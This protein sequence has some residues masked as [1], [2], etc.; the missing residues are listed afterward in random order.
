MD[1]STRM[2]RLRALPSI[3]ELLARPSVSSLLASHSRTLGVTA[4]RE[5]VAGLRARILKGED[6]QIEAKA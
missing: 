2:E 3:D 4:V 6:V 1:D 5:A